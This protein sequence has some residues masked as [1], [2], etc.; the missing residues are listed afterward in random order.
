MPASERAAIL[1]LSRRLLRKVLMSL[2]E[3]TTRLILLGA[4]SALLGVVLVAFQVLAAQ[5]RTYL[6]AQKQATVSG[7]QAVYDT[8]AASGV[9]GRVFVVFDRKVQLDGFSNAE[10]LT[11]F[12][13]GKLAVPVASSTLVSLLIGSGLAREVHIVVPPGDWAEI[14]SK[15]R[16]RMIAAPDNASFVTRLSGGAA[17]ALV[18]VSAT[19]PTLSDKAVVLVNG[20]SEPGYPAGT[21]ES[22]VT[23]QAS[24]LVV[25][26]DGG[27]Q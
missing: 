15:L 3:R 10:A 11:A 26:D 25:V 18:T 27:G 16:R 9:R 7:N 13:Q 21:I 22:F 20:P 1:A 24:D 17:G 12:R 8:V 14:H 5:G 6:P 19:S 4:C 2:P 23:P